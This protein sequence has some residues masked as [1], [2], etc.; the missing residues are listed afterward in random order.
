MSSRLQDYLQRTALYVSRCALDGDELARR[1]MAQLHDLCSA[2]MHMGVAKRASARI[3]WL[4]TE[5]LRSSLQHVANKQYELLVAL[6]RRLPAY[7]GQHR[8]RCPVRSAATVL[9]SRV[10]TAPALLRPAGTPPRSPPFRGYSLR[11]AGTTY[12]AAAGLTTTPR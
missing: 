5:K 6:L 4:A 11:T 7:P 12:A 10:H 8:F 9:H 1:Q 3:A 2:N